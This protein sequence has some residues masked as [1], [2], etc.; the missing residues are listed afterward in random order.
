MKPIALI[1]MMGSGKTTI[2]KQLAKELDL[3]WYDSD[4]FI[5]QST[6]ET[7]NDIFS[8]KGEAYFRTLETKA[9]KTLLTTPCVL[10][11][12]GGIITTKENREQLK[13]NAHV[14]FLETSIETLATRIDDQN[15][16]LLQNQ[17]V[18]QKLRT[19]Y[20]KRESF[21]RECA[22]YTIKTDDKTV[23]EIVALIKQ[24]L[25]Q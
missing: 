14:I 8:T 19:L 12:G 6:H 5:E 11:T 1:G 3:P 16:P 21:Y 9:L 2:G 15:R 22:H 7:I 4:L 13:N 17:P 23:E 10:S 20:D 18:E 24:K 25:S